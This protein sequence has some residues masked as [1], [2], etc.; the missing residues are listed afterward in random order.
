MVLRKNYSKLKATSD[1]MP[2]RDHTSDSSS[3]LGS[4][5]ETVKSQNILNVSHVSEHGVPSGSAA[6]SAVASGCEVID[7][8]HAST[9]PTRTGK[10]HMGV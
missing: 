4:L 8:T 10:I 1:E 2:N 6:A 9:N 3:S 5:Q 7:A